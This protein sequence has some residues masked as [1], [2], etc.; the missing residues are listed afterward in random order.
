MSNIQQQALIKPDRLFP[1]DAPNTFRPTGTA[2][3]LK[4]KAASACDDAEAAKGDAEQMKDTTT[5]A[6]AATP[7]SNPMPPPS[8][9]RVDSRLTVELIR[10][11]PWRQA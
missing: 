7:T 11:Q 8:G 1:W 10:P 5:A 6:V 4:R 3:C 2:R 9:W